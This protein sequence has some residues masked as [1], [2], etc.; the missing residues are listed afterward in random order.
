M[1]TVT[2]ISDCTSI[3]DAIS[4]SLCQ[5][6]PLTEFHLALVGSLVLN[7]TKTDLNLFTHTSK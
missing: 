4:P 2:E 1:A 3:I 7:H 6:K 5:A